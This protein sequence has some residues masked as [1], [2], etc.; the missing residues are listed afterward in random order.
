MHEVKTTIKQL[1]EKLVNNQ[2]H[3][4]FPTKMTANVHDSLDSKTYT[5]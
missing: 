3:P 4:V 2:Q 5:I 1:N